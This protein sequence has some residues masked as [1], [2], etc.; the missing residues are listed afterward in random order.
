MLWLSNTFFIYFVFQN[1]FSFMPLP[2][3]KWEGYSLQVPFHFRPF[4]LQT[5]QAACRKAF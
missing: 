5:V 3:P 2:L 4:Q 1:L